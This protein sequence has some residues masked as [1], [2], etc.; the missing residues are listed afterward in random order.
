MTDARSIIVLGAGIT[1]LWQA[2]TLCDHG[3]DVMVHELDQDA[4]R[5]AS[6]YAGGM[7]A[8]FCEG[9][10]AEAIVSELGQHSIKLWRT[11]YPGVTV[12]GSLVVA[13]SRDRAE[14]QRFA[15]LTETGQ[16]QSPEQ[17]AELEPDLDG[18]FRQGLFFQ[19]EAHLQPRAAMMFLRQRAIEL[20]A[21]FHAVAADAKTPDADWI[22]DCR[23]LGARADLVDLRGVRGEMA[24]IRSAEINLTRP[25]RLLHPRFPLYVVPWGNNRYMV[26]ATVVER[27]DAGPVT[28][29][30]GLELLGHAYALHPGFAEAEIE[31]MAAGVRP[32][33]A[34]NT[35]KIVVDGRR[36]YINGMYRH[37]FLTAPALADI[38]A[39]YLETGAM[40]PEVFRA[41]RGERNPTGNGRTDTA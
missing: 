35:P 10:A 28:V 33:F 19:A 41:D 22:I 24:I 34:D 12:A 27:E 2:V 17:I 4:A 16:P 6:W 40:H 11:V 18:R 36:L 5:P 3:H 31:D 7:L 14:L 39:N 30:S 8:P 26:G 20:G 23:G 37:G 21:T 32:A 9:E 38:T 25:I 1:G 13:N 29:R 15:R